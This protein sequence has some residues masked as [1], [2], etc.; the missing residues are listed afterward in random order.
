MSKQTQAQLNSGT[1]ELTITMGGI[2]RTLRFRNKELVFLGR[3]LNADPVG[4]LQ[5]GGDAVVFLSE[6]IF[7]GLSGSRDARSVSPEVV[8]GWLDRFMRRSNTSP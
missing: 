5:S 8:C 2:E 4:F 6:A 3:R 1:S 7:C